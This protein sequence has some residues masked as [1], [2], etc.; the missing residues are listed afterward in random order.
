MRNERE[1]KRRLSRLSVWLIRGPALAVASI[2]LLFGL[3]EIG[4]RLAGYQAIYEVYSEPSLF[5]RYDDLLG[6]S[7]TPGAQGIYVGPRPWPV[8]FR[9]PVSINSIGLRGPEVVDLPPGGYRILMLGDSLVAGFEVAYEQTFAAQVEK[10]LNEAVD[11]PV[12]VVNAGVRGYGTDQEYL[13]YRER[14]RLL[15]P[16]LVVAFMSL[17]DPEDNITLHRMRRPFGKAAFCL[18]G[19]GALEL[20]GHPIPHFPACSE[21]TLD[22]DF[23]PVRIDGSLGRG[24]CVLEMN[25]SDRSSFFTWVT[26][27]I[28][29]NPTLLHWLYELTS[30]GQVASLSTLFSVATAAAE[31]V[32]PPSLP[33]PYALTTALLRELAHS[34]RASGAEFRLVTARDQW[35]LL[36]THALERDGIEPIFGELRLREE[37]SRY[38]HFQN[39]DH[40]NETGHALLARSLAQWLLPVLHAGRPAPVAKP[41]PGE[42]PS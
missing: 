36:D 12:Q 20:R 29:R 2:A 4:F 13:W 40:L 25:L 3:L 42:P 35:P 11:F 31:E 38:L 37:E 33:P 8:E 39:D 28:R 9:A 32:A 34:V 1:R 15:R 10:R 14:G 18:R 30:P 22:A 41:E 5:W 21:V 19:N 26:M 24:L 16:D 7:H 6:W 27:R 17:N 23:E